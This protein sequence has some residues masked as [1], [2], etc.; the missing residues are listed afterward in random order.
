MI[1][2]GK[3]QQSGILKLVIDPVVNQINLPTQ[4][5]KINQKM[6]VTL[7][8]QDVFKLLEYEN[9]RFDKYLKKN[10]IKDLD[11]EVE[12]DIQ[13]QSA[14][15]FEEDNKKVL[16]FFVTDECQAKL[17]SLVQN[18]FAQ[19]NLQQEFNSIRKQTPDIGRKFHISYANRSGNPFD[20]IA[21]VW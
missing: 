2:T 18:W 8:H 3:L 7:V 9:K 15:I 4:G 21:V 17:N 1:V 5:L 14:Q 13:L 16:V 20:S 6:H 11:K 19:Y 12:V 10:P